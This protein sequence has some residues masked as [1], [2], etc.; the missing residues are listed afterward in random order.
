[1]RACRNVIN[2]LKDAFSK[3]LSAVI[4]Q[5]AMR[6]SSTVVNNQQQGID[7]IGQ[8]LL[9]AAGNAYEPM[10]ERHIGRR[11]V[12]RVKFGSGDE[13]RQVEVPGYLAEYSE[14]YVAVFNTGQRIDRADV[15]NLADKHACK[16]YEATF[17]GTELHIKNVGDQFVLLN[18]VVAKCGRGK[19]NR[20]MMPGVVIAPCGMLAVNCGEANEL[21]L[22]IH[23]TR[24]VDLVCPRASATVY[25]GGP[26]VDYTEEESGVM[27]AVADE[28]EGGGGK[29]D[30]VAPQAAAEQL[31]KDDDA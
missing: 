8:T 2:S 19:Q 29:E 16:E 31:I 18:K 17:A 25:F 7:E 3:A 24:E 1:M 15:I 10:L 11:V 13:T 4:G 14:K 6:K 5:M 28:L 22:N 23:I 30:G 21:M 20:V 27:Q 26:G 12:M 9:G